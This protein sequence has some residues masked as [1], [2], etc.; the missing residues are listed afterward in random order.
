ME[1]ESST[2]NERNDV[3]SSF[4]RGN[5]IQSTITSRRKF[6]GLKEFKDH[7]RRRGNGFWIAANIPSSLVIYFLIAPTTDLQARTGATPTK[8]AVEIS[9]MV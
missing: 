6:L 3:L 2:N 8:T 4:R 1:K 9:L 7:F 5:E